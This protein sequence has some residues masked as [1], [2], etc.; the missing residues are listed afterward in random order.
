MSFIMFA[1][2]LV[3]LSETHHHY[4]LQLTD[5]DSDEVLGMTQIVTNVLMARDIHDSNGLL[6]LPHSR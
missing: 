2:L 3:S 6:E 1:H 4:I 5:V